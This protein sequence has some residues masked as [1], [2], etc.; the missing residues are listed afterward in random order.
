MP[1]RATRGRARGQ[2]S[3]PDRGCARGYRGGAAG[4]GAQTSSASSAPTPVL[5]S[6]PGAQSQLL[7]EV[8]A[9][10]RDF[11]HVVQ[12]TRTEVPPPLPPVAPTVVA[13]VPVVVQAEPRAQSA[14]RDFGRRNPPT[15]SGESNPI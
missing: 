13:P 12:A 1:S 11:A 3:C 10:L 2:P 6:I 15:F 7:R 8:A 4:Q 14:M 5:K 9:A